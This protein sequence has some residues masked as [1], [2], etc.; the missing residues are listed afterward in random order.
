[1]RL[2]ESGNKAGLG[3]GL[4]LARHIVARHGGTLT[5]ETGRTK[6]ACF[7]CCLP[8]TNKKAQP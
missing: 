3:L 7:I 1:V 6:G 5:V 4:Y 8:A 2:G